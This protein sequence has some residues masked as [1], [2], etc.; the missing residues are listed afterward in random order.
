[1]NTPT[2]ISQ[3]PLLFSN[4]HLCRAY[5]SWNTVPSPI[6]SR[7]QSS[8]RPSPS[9]HCCTFIV[10]SGPFFSPEPKLFTR[11]LQG[12]SGV[13]QQEVFLRIYIV[14]KLRQ[15]LGGSLPVYM[16]WAGCSRDCILI[17]QL[18]KE[19]A[20]HHSFPTGKINGLPGV[21]AG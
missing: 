12:F 6:S 13:L 10:S 17:S 19:M 16:K 20:G 2:C 5:L 3:P 11:L 1:M 8:T 15:P 4:S 21:G 18:G 7:T 14:L 9:A